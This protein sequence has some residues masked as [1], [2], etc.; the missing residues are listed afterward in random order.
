MIIEFLHQTDY[1]FWILLLGSVTIII[2]YIIFFKPEKEFLILPFLRLF[3]VVILLIGLLQPNITQ[4]IQRERERELSVFVD[5]SMSMGYHKESS[6]IRLNKDLSSF[7]EKLK[8]KDIKHSIYHFDN[9]IY[10]VINEIPLTATG[11]TTNI[12]EI[13]KSAEHENPETSMGYLMITDGQNTLGIDPKQSVTDVSIPIFSLGVGDKSALVDISIKSV[14]APT[15]AI[16][17]EVIEIIGTVESFGD[18]NQ[19]LTVSLYDENK[20]I[21]SKYIRVIGGGSQTNIR[22]G[23]APDQ[24]GESLYTMRISSIEDELNIANNQHSFSISILQDQYN[25]AI[26]TGAPSYNTGVLKKILSKMPRTSVNH[27]I[28]NK[29]EFRPGLKEFWEKKYELIILDNFPVSQ[30]SKSWYSFLKKKIGSHKS[31]LAWFSGPSTQ[32]RYVSTLFSIFGLKD[33]N[34]IFE[35]KLT[36]WTLTSEGEKIIRSFSMHPDFIFR[37]LEFPPLNPGLQLTHQ[38]SWMYPLASFKNG[39]NTPVLLTGETNNVR[40]AVWSPTNLHALHYNLTSTKSKEFSKILL[41]GLFSWLLRT[42]GN[43][44]LHFRLN[45]NNYQ[46]GEE[47]EISGIRY[48][49]SAKGESALFYIIVKDSIVSS[50]ELQFNPLLE[51][52]EGS[53]WASFPGTNEYIVEY[54]DN[55]GT[56]DQKG[57]FYVEKSQVEL[58]KVYLNEELLKYISGE[59]GGEYYHWANMDSMILQ[60]DPKITIM[61]ETNKTRPF[62]KWWIVVILISILS[63]EWGLRRKFGFL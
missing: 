52:W 43:E 24:L 13:I 4:V 55:S 53:L 50:T 22:F 35:D 2:W 21:G 14:D 9:S 8:N 41:S 18:I 62:E 37:E 39:G 25:V 58:N 44:T 10:P 33:A 48:S 49:E 38:H 28:Q 27:F 59:T 15:V 6:L 36:E 34:W 54:K 7:R 47:I 32:E 12:G 26:L 29:K 17:N 30:M 63:L 23:F 31:S 46:Q 19:R 1:W 11:S 56:Y 61:T 16:N 5:N 60:L 51:R 42:G 40:M 3:F 45:K 57:K 20:L